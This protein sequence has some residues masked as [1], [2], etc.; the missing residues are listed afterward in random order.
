M[1][2]DARYR[3]RIA[4]SKARLDEDLK[5]LASENPGI[6]ADEFVELAR[7]RLNCPVDPEYA[8]RLVAETNAR[9]P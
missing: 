1:T 7:A 4:A 9:R 2:V 5:E 3:K 6:G 8:E